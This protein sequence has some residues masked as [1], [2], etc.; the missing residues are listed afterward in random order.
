MVTFEEKL[1]VGQIG[2]SLIAQWLRLRGCHVMPVYEMEIGSGKGP[3]LF[4]ATGQLMRS[5]KTKMVYWRKE[6]LIKKAEYED[7]VNSVF[8]NQNLIS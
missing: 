3:R 6:S 7:V 5:D 1:K 2:E 8:E 4:S